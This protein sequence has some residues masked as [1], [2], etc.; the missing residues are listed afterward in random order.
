MKKIALKIV[1]IILIVV[2]IL[3]FNVVMAVTKSELNAS[4]NETNQKIEEAKEELENINAQKSETLQQVE[5]LIM[6]ISSAQSEIDELD[7]QIADMNS[8]IEEAQ[9]KIN[10][11]LRAICSYS[12]LQNKMG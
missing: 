2:V 1:G 6:Q 3:Q 5:D 8:Q 12:V 9:N 7:T 11:K 4:S 10:E